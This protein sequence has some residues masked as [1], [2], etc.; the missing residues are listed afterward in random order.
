MADDTLRIDKFLWFAR[1]ARTRALA[2]TI[3]ERG[4]VRLC[5]RR[6]ERAHAPVRVGDV[7]S[8]PC[9]AGVRVIRVES[10]PR[11]RISAAHAPVV[12][13]ELQGGKGGA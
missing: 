13:T 2:Q 10:L 7:L 8:V 9:H 11:A 5:G 1:L 4:H 6:I 3:A 12:Y